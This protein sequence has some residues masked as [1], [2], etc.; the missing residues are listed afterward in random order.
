VTYIS[1]TWVWR[2]DQTAAEPIAHELGHLEAEGP[3]D[4]EGAEAYGMAVL[5]GHPDGERWV[6]ICG[7]TIEKLSRL[8]PG[9][10]P[11]GVGGS[12]SGSWSRL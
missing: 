3:N 12:A 10:M 8:A 11:R 4:E 9:L 6:D 2:N 1:R 5:L 7:D